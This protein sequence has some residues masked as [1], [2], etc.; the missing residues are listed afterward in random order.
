MQL[1]DKDQLLLKPS[2]CL[3]CCVVYLVACLC[4][5]AG[6]NGLQCDRKTGK[7][8]CSPGVIGKR[9]DMCDARTTGVMPKCANCHSC[10]DQWD[11]TIREQELNLTN[12]VAGSNFTSPGAIYDQEL[13]TLKRM[14]KGI[15]IMMQNR[16]LSDQDVNK[17]RRELDLF[18]KNLTSISARSDRVFKWSENTTKRNMMANVELDRLSKYG[19]DLVAKVSSKEYFEAIS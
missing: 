17:F 9:C 1:K 5:P 10:Y 12:Y 3:S 14:L 16:S 8:I 19:A 6:S 18:R 4:N 15:E 13:E 2:T 11:K 7:C